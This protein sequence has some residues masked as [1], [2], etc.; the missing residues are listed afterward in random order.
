M[1]ENN[2]GIH[3]REICR[4]MNKKMGV[5]QYHISV[6]QK[7]NLIRSVK[8][9]RYK[10]FFSTKNNPNVY[11]PHQ[12]MDIEQKRIREELITSMKRKTQKMIINQLIQEELIYHQQLAKLCNVSPQAITFHCQRLINMKIIESVQNGHQKYYKLSD[13]SRK[14]VKFL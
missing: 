4:K 9:G 1:I 14:I 5:V 13:R 3:F 8:D 6:L 7:C 2:E 12:E 11:K 10:C